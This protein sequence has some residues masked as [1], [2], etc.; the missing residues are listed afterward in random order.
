M[1]LDT[2]NRDV[3]RHINHALFTLS[4]DHYTYVP[5]TE[6]PARSTPL[7]PPDS[8]VEVDAHLHNL[9]SS[10]PQHPGHNRWHDKPY[11]LIVETNGRAGAEGEHSP[12]DALVPSIVADYS[13]VEAIDDSAF[14]HA[15]GGSVAHAHSTLPDSASPTSWKR[16]DFV[17]DD[18]IREE[19]TR[20]E[21]ALLDIVRDSDDSVLWFDAYGADWIQNSGNVD[22]P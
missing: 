2:Q 13:V 15:L 12:V 14:A 18:Y 10:H 4:L 19:S 17:V 6:D 16:L 3:L 5:L 21:T 22:C 11:T 9:R 8:P 20:V 7:P 1:T